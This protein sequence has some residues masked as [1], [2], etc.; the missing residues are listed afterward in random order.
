MTYYLNA[1]TCTPKEIQQAILASRTPMGDNYL[2]VSKDGHIEVFSAE[3]RL[4]SD[5]FKAKNGKFYSKIPSA[6]DAGVGKYVD[7]DFAASLS[8]IVK[9]AWNN[10]RA[11]YID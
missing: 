3:Y 2:L 10:G 4:T 11:G 9:D 7:I 6:D 1:A 5:G 8:D